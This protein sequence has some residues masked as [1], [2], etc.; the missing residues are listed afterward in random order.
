MIHPVSLSLLLS[1]PTTRGRTDVVGGSKAAINIQ[2]RFILMPKLIDN[3]V[4]SRKIGAG[5]YG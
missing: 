4:L 3:Y 1:N 5:Q 2:I